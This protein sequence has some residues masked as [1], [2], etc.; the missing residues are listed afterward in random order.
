MAKF[1]K[2][3]WYV[4]AWSHE[5]GEGLFSRTI[6]SEP[7]LLFR[8]ADGTAVAI[9]D[10]CPHR[11]APLHKGKL[12]DGKVECPYH[13]LQFD[14][15]GTCVH[16]PH[17]DHKI[18]SAARVK[19][20]PVVERDTLLWVWPGDP[21]LADPSKIPDFNILNDTTTYTH[22]KGAV[23]SMN[24]A[25]D[26]ILD[27]LMDLTHAAYLH[28]DNLGSEAVKRGKMNVVQEGNNLT[29]QNWW[30]NGLPAP[31]FPMTG[32]CSPDNPVDYWVDV[33]WKPLGV[34][35]F[36][37][38]ITP[39]G[40]PKSEGVE[41]NSAQILTPET[42]HSTHYFWRMFRNYQKE[43][44]ELT[45]GIEVAVKQAFQSQDEAMIEEVAERMDGHDLWDLNP[46]LL[47]TDTAAVRVRRILQQ[48]N[49]TEMHA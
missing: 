24:I 26:L 40:R 17:G 31:V 22:T 13:G 10:T 4:A 14:G 41:L 9:G 15:T 23:I 20:Y 35:F 16:N 30:P 49:E 8:Q 37:A 25:F 32:A 48:L 28:L 38:G 45:A 19:H 21:A 44:A 43:N 47:A 42:E 27:N 18:P 46:V 36:D 12:V 39:T 6:L 1:P 3:L 33:H 29:T 7:I 2:N 34:M 11:F 5:V